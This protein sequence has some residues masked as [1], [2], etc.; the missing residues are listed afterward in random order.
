VDTAV[1]EAPI[2]S[3]ATT[4]VPPSSAPSAPEDTQSDAAG[5]G[6][7]GEAQEAPKPEAPNFRDVWKG[8]S[9]QEREEYLRETPWEE[10]FGASDW[11]KGKVGAQKQ[12]TEREQRAERERIAAEVRAEIEREA[13][14]RRLA[15]LAASDDA[16]GVLEEVKRR[17]QTKAEAQ[18]SAQAEARANALLEHRTQTTIAGAVKAIADALPEGKALLWAEDGQ[19]RR[20]APEGTVADGLKEF[21]AAAVDLSAKAELAKRVP[22]LRK[23]IEAAVRAELNAERLGGEPSPDTRGGS[24]GQ[25]TIT[26]AMYEAHRADN[27]WIDKHGFEAAR[28]AALGWPNG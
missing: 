26:R 27:D 13:E 20:Y 4:E 28:L 14:E 1:Q 7:D 8:M 10:T 5:T 3:A 9:P 6:Q 19:P 21:I 25:G 16:F 18:A 22:D 12:Q 2:E 15:E 11:L 17:T 23:E 24:A